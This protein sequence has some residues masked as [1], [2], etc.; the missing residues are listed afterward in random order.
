MQQ[1]SPAD[2][3]RILAAALNRPAGVQ[4]V[5]GALAEVPGVEY[6][7]GRPRGFMRAETPATLRAAEWTFSPAKSGNAIEAGHTVRGVVLSRATLA[8]VDAA[9]RL[10]P[11]VLE[12]AR[13]Q[14][15]EALDQA[16]SVIGALGEVLGL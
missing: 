12:A 4:L 2:A 5:F 7:P 13:Q 16:E 6:D 14:G 1:V 10:A 9:V 8:P 11:A 3:E 15:G